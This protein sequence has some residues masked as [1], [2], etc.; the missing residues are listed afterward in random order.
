MAGAN[1]A[2]DDA[3][4]LSLLSSPPFWGVSSS[5]VVVDIAA[6]THC[7]LV[8][9][10]NE[11]H[12]L[13]AR[14][15]RAMET[16]HTNIPD[17]I[18]EPSCEA[19]GYGMLVADGMGG[20]PAGEVASRSAVVKLLE[21]VASTP[22]WIMRFDQNEMVSIV[23]QRMRQRFREID[24]ALRRRAE[25]SRD[26]EGMGTTL[27]VAVSLG[28]LLIVGHIGDSR[29]YLLRGKQ[30][31]QL[32]RDDTLAQALIDSGVA[33]LED[34]ATR[35][36]RHVLTAAVGSIGEPVDPQVERLELVCGDQL[37][38]CTDGLTEMVKE[39]SIAAALLEAKTAGQACQ[40][41]IDLALSAGGT[42]NVTVALARYRFQD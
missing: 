30:L 21:L 15:S 8:R 32:T 19:S 42:D 11:D 12:Y 40:S 17:S 6:A 1:E 36:M 20:M 25:S 26:L 13:V 2:H 33:D 24:V 18:L 34:T 22:D 5:S 14:F 3:L 35:A 37:L 23:M 29:A 10:N 16:L 28:T 9:A 39:E 27:T 38:L 4:D 7:G 41:L 31:R